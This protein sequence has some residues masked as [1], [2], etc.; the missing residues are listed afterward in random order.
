MKQ[1]KA[2]AVLHSQVTTKAAYTAVRQML[3]GT[4][5][6]LAPAQAEKHTLRERQE[7][8][9]WPPK[10]VHAAP[11]HLSPQRTCPVSSAVR[12]LPCSTRTRAC[13]PSGH[14]TSA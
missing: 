5:I 1:S 10:P 12:A 13:K 14:D 3:G 6:C 11:P 2:T 9:N 7:E 8:G 4:G